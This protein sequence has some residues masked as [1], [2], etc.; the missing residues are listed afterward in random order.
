MTTRAYEA[1]LILKA[2]GTEQEIA[3]HVTDLEA[4]VQKVGG[5]IETT[6]G[7]GRRKLAFRILRQVEGNY[8]LLR[9]Q[10]P[11]ESVTELERLFRLQD[12]VVRFMILGEDDVST[13]SISTRSVA[14]RSSMAPT[15]S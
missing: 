3:K 8:H 4:L 7:L 12:A 10:A 15:R 9:F 13:S 14:P 11:T 6:Q 1:L 2:A 5:K